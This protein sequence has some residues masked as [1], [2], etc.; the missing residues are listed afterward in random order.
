MRGGSE[1]NRA[2]WGGDYQNISE[3]YGRGSLENGRALLRGGVIRIQQ[4]LGGGGHKNIREPYEGGGC[5]RIQLSL[6]GGSDKFY[7]YTTKKLNPLLLPPPFVHLKRKGER[8]LRGC[9]TDAD[10]L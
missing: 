9:Q 4:S 5:M 8:S 1:Y 3:P 7:L 6:T 10:N 2:L